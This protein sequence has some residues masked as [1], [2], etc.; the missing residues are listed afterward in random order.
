MPDEAISITRI[1]KIPISI[2]MFL[3]LGA[4]LFYIVPLP[5]N[6]IKTLSPATYNLRQ[7]YML[8]PSFWSPLSL[9]P[10]ATI[11]YLI[12]FPTYIMIF[13][14]VVSKI[15]CSPCR[16]E[17][18]EKSEG[19]EAISINEQRAK[20]HI[21]KRTGNF[22]MLGALTSILAILFHSLCDFN[23][24]IPA[25]AIYFTVMLAIVT[26]LSFSGN[27]IQNTK[28]EI[29][30]VINYKF[31]NKLVNAIITIG[32]IIALFGILQKLSYNGK[33]YWLITKDGGHFGPYINRDHFAG[34]MQ[35]CTFLAIAS[36]IA[37]IAN[38]SFPHIKR[39][40]DK[41][42]WF[43]T[44]E[45]NTTL[46]YLF[47]SVVMV[48]ALFMST[49]RGGIMSFCAALS[50]FYF[51]CIISAERKKRNRLLFASV[52]VIILIVI[53]IIWVGPEETL[54]RFE[55]L[56]KIVRTIIKER[57][58]LS[59]L[60]PI[61]WV[62]TWTLIKHFPVTGVGAGNYSYVFPMCRTFATDYGVLREAHNDYLQL[63]AEMGII[64]WSVIIFFFGWYIRRFG[65][66][67]KRLGE[68]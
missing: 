26:G 62:D 6:V 35:M 52:L 28:Y 56:N 23:L 18:P 34:Y 27:E 22:F 61:M 1:I 51:I 53:M 31:V 12:K 57:A 5:A 59:E 55:I 14:F 63:I 50:V 65:E 25:N 46:I 3:V 43:S 42:V 36:F 15:I 54:N 41:I 13:L 20:R 17:A 9:Y 39:F 30:D 10:R 40:K 24:Q 67:F 19:D 4:V 16:L 21:D 64:G 47:L 37:K 68:W 33:I 2:G 7:T 58:V 60:R 44:K 66:C 38:S 29:R 48:T 49:S 11:T 45:A 32:F 8:D